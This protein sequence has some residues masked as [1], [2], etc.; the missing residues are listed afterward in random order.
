MFP[1][2]NVVDWVTTLRSAPLTSLYAL[3]DPAR[4]DRVYFDYED[5]HGSFDSA[6]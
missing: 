1:I 6:R 5:G 3:V 2:R 4:K